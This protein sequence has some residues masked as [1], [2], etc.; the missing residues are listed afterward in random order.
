M[1]EPLVSYLGARRL[2]CPQGHRRKRHKRDRRAQFFDIEAEVEDEDEG[3]DDEK[4][5]EEIEGFIDND[6][7]DDLVEAG[8][9][10]D[11]RRHRELDR[12]REM[13]A[14]LDAEKQAEILKQRYGG[15]R[16]VKGLGDSTIVPKRL[17]L[18]SVHDP[19]IWAVR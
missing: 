2:T 13:E 1:E 6:H 9:L 3:E 15:R 16:P 10:D 19:S 12:R 14:S 5:G 17:L 7:P 11:D 18:P 8:R 4:D